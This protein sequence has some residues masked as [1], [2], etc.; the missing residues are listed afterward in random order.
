MTSFSQVQRRKT[1]GSLALPLAAA[2]LLAACAPTFEARVARF[3]ALPTP[4]AKTFYVEPVNAAYVGG[5]EFAAYAN[6]VKQQMLAN[7][8]SEVATQG[9]AEVTV[10]LDYVVGPPRER[11]QTRPATNVGWGGGWGGGGWGGGGWGWHPYWG[12]GWGGGGWGGGG[13]GGGWGG[14]FN[15]GWNQQEIYSVTEF[16]TVMAIK[17]LRSADKQAMFEGRAE[18]TSRTNNLPALMPNLVR[19]MFTRFPGTNGEVVRVRFDPNDPSS[20]PSVST[21]R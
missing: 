15:G 1:L 6:L 4:P 5:L 12:P 10:L 17:M 2:A 19:A 13:W 16:N 14:G 21:V 20:Q 8:F 11:I 9:A 3:S 18:T 7:G